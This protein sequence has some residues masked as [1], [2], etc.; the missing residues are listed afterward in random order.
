MPPFAAVA[1][2]DSRNNTGFVDPKTNIRRHKPV[3]RIFSRR[4]SER[5][6]CGW[7]RA[8]APTDAAAPCRSP[9]GQLW[10]H[11]WQKML[12]GLAGTHTWSGEKAQQSALVE[13]RE[14]MSKNISLG[15]WWHI[16]SVA[17][18][19]SELLQVFHSAG[20][21]FS[22]SKTEN[23][24]HFNLTKKTKKILLKNP[25]SNP[26]TWSWNQ[27]NPHI[28]LNSISTQVPTLTRTPT[29]NTIPPV[30]Q[31]LSQPEP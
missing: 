19:A 10:S 14:R 25:N 30:S 31:H 8:A 23:F 3:W 13:Q 15:G 21:T 16:C 27:T 12:P 26:Q 1:G 6:P 2:Q 11:S 29:Q 22:Q 24:C 17:Q 18:N 28:T 7:C 5:A 9:P 20:K 4:R